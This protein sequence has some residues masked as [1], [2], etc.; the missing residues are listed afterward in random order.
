ME[1]NS[2][3]GLRNELRGVVDY[4]APGNQKIDTDP[5]CNNLAVLHNILMK[6]GKEGPPLLFPKMTLGYCRK[7]CIFM[8]S[9]QESGIFHHTASKTT[10]PF[11]DFESSI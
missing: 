6:V 7:D 4:Q 3:Q 8:N 10:F 11:E 5:V 1:D 9:Y 2:G